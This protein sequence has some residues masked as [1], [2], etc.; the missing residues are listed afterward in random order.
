MTT[1]LR[2]EMVAGARCVGAS[3]PD[4]P[5]F[6]EGYELYRPRK[7]PCCFGAGADGFPTCK[8]DIHSII[9]PNPTIDFRNKGKPYFLRRKDYFEMIANEILAENH[10]AT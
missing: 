9:H 2:Q 1:F 7:V 10:S 8:R 6:N 5:F 3:E 4:G